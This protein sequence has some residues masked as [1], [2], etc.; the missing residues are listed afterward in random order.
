MIEAIFIPFGACFDLSVNTI[1]RII[2]NPVIAAIV[3]WKYSIIKSANGINPA[4][5][6]GQSGHDKPT[7][8][9]LTYPPINI[10]VKSIE[11]VEKESI[12]NNMVLLSRLF[13]SFLFFSFLSLF[14]I[15]IFSIILFYFFT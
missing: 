1:V 11:S 6:R 2:I 4:G 8:D 13:L 10:K 7:P 14:C 12:F 15:Y 3:R 9:A 5:H